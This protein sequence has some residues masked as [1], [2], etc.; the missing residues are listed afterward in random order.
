MLPVFLQPCE[1][2]YETNK[3]SVFL[4]AVIFSSFSM[5]AENANEYTVDPSVG[6]AFIK[7]I[8]YEHQMIYNEKGADCTG[9]L[10]ISM[11]PPE[12]TEGVIL[13]RSV[14]HDRHGK[15]IFALKGLYTDDLSLISANG[16]SLTL[17]HI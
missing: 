6:S 17:I 4:L 12:G 9:T 10:N 14:G 7:E 15:L 2:T 1:Y 3:I 5:I 16:I 11:S 8:A 13:A